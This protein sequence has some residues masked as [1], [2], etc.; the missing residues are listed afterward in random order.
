[1]YLENKF[2]FIH[3]KWSFFHSK[4]PRKT[5]RINLEMICGGQSR[6]RLRT[7][8]RVVTGCG[9]APK[10]WSAA[11]TPTTAAGRFRKC[12][13][14]VE[15]PR[16]SRL[17][18]RFR[19]GERLQ[20]MRSKSTLSVFSAALGLIDTN[21]RWFSVAAFI[22]PT[23]SEL[24]NDVF[25]FLFY[26]FKENVPLSH[27]VNEHQI[28]TSARSPWGESPTINSVFRWNSVSWKSPEPRKKVSTC[29]WN[30]FFGGFLI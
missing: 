26:F 24:P 21:P 28:S 14:L 19:K 10:S 13:I 22:S 9:H 2:S 15:R 8:P 3:I 4:A 5:K 23:E 18:S 7:R 6:D 27:G 1:M 17:A 29:R 16:T 30:L 20:T 25:M 11:D 12:L